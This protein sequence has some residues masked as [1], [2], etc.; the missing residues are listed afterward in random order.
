MFAIMIGILTW[1]F[2]H[3][4][5]HDNETSRPYLWLLPP[6]FALWA[7]SRR[8]RGRLGGGGNI[9]LWAMLENLKTPPLVGTDY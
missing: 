4:H 6:L 9:L 2:S 7:N 1:S 8:F 3:W 5:K